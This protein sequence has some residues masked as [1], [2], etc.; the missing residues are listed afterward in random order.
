MEE[1]E[2]AENDLVERIKT[3]KNRCE[4][5]LLILDNGREDLIYTE[6]EDMYYGTQVILDKYCIKE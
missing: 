2:T 1:P 3:T 6:L 5:A 4:I